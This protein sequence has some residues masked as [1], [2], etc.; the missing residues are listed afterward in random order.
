M[1]TNIEPHECIILVQPKKIGTHENK[2]I[3]G[4]D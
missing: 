3:N 1:G 4:I 2:A